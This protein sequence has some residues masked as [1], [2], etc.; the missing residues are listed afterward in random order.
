MQVRFAANFYCKCGHAMAFM[1]SLSPDI[2]RRRIQ[3]LHGA[4]KQYGI[5]YEEPTLTAYRVGQAGEP[6]APTPMVYLMC[7]DPER[8]GYLAISTI[9]PSL[10]V[11]AGSEEAALGQL[12]ES[13]PGIVVGTVHRIETKW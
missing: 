12:V 3:C 13:T 2:P 11:V 1:D 6:A 4:C 10:L 8:G 9:D 5:V 7:I